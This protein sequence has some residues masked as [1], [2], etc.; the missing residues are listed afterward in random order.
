VFDPLGEV[1][2]LH[3]RRQGGH[4]NF[5]RHFSILSAPSNSSH[6]GHVFGNRRPCRPTGYSLEL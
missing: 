4:E 3:G 1:A 2:L 5:N 6:S